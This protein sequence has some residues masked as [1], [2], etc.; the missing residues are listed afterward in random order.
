MP[1]RF[2]G[3]TSVNDRKFKGSGQNAVPTRALVPTGGYSTTRCLTGRITTAGAY[4][5]SKDT[6]ASTSDCSALYAQ[7]CVDRCSNPFP[8]SIRNGDSRPC[9]D[10]FERRSCP[11]H[12][13][14][15][16]ETKAG[17]CFR[18]KAFE[19]HPSRTAIEMT[20]LVSNTVPKPPQIGNAFWG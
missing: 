5:L 3:E 19:R 18:T 20:T 13:D 17:V 4:I 14:E 1:R 16:H 11:N 8:G 6:N 2:A 9:L 7:R 12:G 10:V 15:G